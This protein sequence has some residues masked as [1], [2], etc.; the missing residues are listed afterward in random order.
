MA[1]RAVLTY[2]DPRLRDV[3]EPVTR[4]DDE[5]RALV[6]DLLETLYTRSGLGLS[7]PQIGVTR[8]VIV[9]DHSNDQSSPEVYVNPEI[10]ARS[11]FGLVEES[12]LS[13]PGAIVNVIRATQV[14]VRAC[15]GNGEPF[16]RDLIDMPAVCLEHEMDHLRGIL[17][18]D[19]LSLLARW[20]W[21]RNL[22]RQRLAA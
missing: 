21:R 12:C 2:P 11:R 17:L 20:R 8:Q 15:D 14:R 16:E 19:K 10:L 22:R 18:A 6:A 1:N 9:A 7:A 3:A 5:L 4:F 13:V